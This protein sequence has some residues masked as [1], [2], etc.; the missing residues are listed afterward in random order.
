MLPIHFFATWFE[1]VRTLPFEMQ[2]VLTLCEGV[3]KV[4]RIHLVADMN[5]C[6]IFLGNKSVSRVISLRATDI[7]GRARG[8]KL[9]QR[10]NISLDEL[11]PSPS[12]GGHHKCLYTFSRHSI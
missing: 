4:V 3:T 2:S 1:H 10:Q 12:S 7:K 9:S 5:A 11:K 6:V 8:E